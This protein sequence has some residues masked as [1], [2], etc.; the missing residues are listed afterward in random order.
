MPP[1]Y[2]IYWAISLLIRFFSV[3]VCMC[4]GYFATSGYSSSS[5]KALMLE[6]LIHVI[7]CIRTTESI[8]VDILQQWTRQQQWDT[9][10]TKSTYSGWLRISVERAPFVVL[11]ESRAGNREIA[12]KR[13]TVLAPPIK[14]TDHYYYYKHIVVY[15]NV[16]EKEWHRS[17]ETTGTETVFK[18]KK[19]HVRAL[20]TNYHTTG[21]K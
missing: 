9:V 14:S 10:H 17:N 1:M 5:L 18:W 19:L 11:W 7:W 15:C 20:H 4:V 3:C 16:A 2:G 21:G 8:N 6:T 12:H 13:D